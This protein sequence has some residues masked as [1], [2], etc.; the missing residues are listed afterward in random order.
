MQL[1]SPAFKNNG[2]IPDAYTCTG[3]EMIPPLEFRDIPLETTFLAL[4][5]EDPDAPSG[6]FDHWIV[7]N[8]PASTAVIEEGTEPLGIRGNNSTGKVGYVGPCPPSGVHH[9]IFTEKDILEAMGT[10]IVERAKL[11][12][13]YGKK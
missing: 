4:V 2:M 6:T 12:G 1:S 3:E 8:I 10:H 13:M 5:M 7:F 11:V 9:Y